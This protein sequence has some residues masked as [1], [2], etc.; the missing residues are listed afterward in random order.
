MPTHMHANMHAS[1]NACIRQ[2]HT[3]SHVSIPFEIV[4]VVS[5]STLT[6]EPSHWVYAVRDKRTAGAEVY[7]AT[8]P[9]PVIDESDVSTTNICPLAEVTLSDAAVPV[10]IFR[11][12][13]A[14]VSPSYTLTK[15]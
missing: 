1:L 11:R 9:D 2:M 8:K 13:P 14:V 12:R 3:D 5:F 10:N 15:S 4:P 7:V 6:T